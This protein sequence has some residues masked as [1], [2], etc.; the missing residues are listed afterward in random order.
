[1]LAAQGFRADFFGVLKA[2]RK[3]EF[4][5]TSEF[6]PG[7]TFARVLRENK[8]I[9]IHLDFVTP[10]DEDGLRFLGVFTRAPG[11]CNGEVS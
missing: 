1:V 10:K 4:L 7:V 11:E 6:S 5:G 3:Q 8:E 2:S 9:E